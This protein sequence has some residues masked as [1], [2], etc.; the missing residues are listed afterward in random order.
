[1]PTPTKGAFCEILLKS[2]V[3]SEFSTVLEDLGGKSGEGDV[4]FIDTIARKV[5]EES[6]DII[7]KE[8]VRHHLEGETP[9]YINGCKYLLFIKVLQSS[10]YFQSESLPPN[11]RWHS[12]LYVQRYQQKSLNIRINDEVM[13]KLSELMVISRMSELKL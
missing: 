12:L 2:N 9:M 5:S 7:S 11:V 6:S 8:A 4:S 10:E 3:K 13:D 1:M